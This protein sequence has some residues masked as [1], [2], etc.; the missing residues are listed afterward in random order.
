MNS[1]RRRQIFANPN[2]RDKGKE[3]FNEILE[4]CQRDNASEAA[5]LPRQT[6]KAIAAFCPK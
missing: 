5:F 3:G 1:D 4:W 6:L 2:N